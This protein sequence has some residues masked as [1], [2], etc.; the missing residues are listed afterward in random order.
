M[1]LDLDDRRFISE[2]AVSLERGVDYIKP[3]R[4]PFE[5]RLLF[6]KTAVDDMMLSRA[7]MPAGVRLAFR[8]DTTS[9]EGSIAA[10]VPNEFNVPETFAARLDV[11]CDG[12]LC[13]TFDLAAGTSFRID[14][15]PGR[16]KWVELWLP[17]YREF[18]LRTLCLS[19]GATIEPHHDERRRWLVYGSSYTQSRG[20]ASPWFAW[21]AV[22]ARVHRRSS[23]RC[24][25][26]AAGPT[27]A[28]ENQESRGASR[29]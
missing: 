12:H 23:L 19:A 25:R 9:I 5:Q 1:N 8:S 11:A 24:C 27:S 13:S 6:G 3:W 16:P 29:P 2:G 4:V 10:I 18:R 15:L 26:P 22:A 17:E 28:G 7:G 14:G 20:A 21:P